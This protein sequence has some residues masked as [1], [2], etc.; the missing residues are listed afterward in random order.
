MARKLTL[1]GKPPLIGNNVSH[2]HRKTK[3]AWLP[4][5]QTKTLYSQSLGRSFRMTITVETLRTLDRAGGLDS[6]L[7]AADPASLGM[8]MRRVRDQISARV[9]PSA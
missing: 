7:L 8:P 2:S 6:F 4:N 9:A 5:I 3:R 1:G